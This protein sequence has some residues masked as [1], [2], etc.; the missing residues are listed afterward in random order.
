VFDDGKP[1]TGAA[2]CAPAP[3]IDPVKAFSQPW[4]M[5]SC[6]ALPLVRD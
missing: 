4:N 1:K 5:H 6:N 3:G 2:I